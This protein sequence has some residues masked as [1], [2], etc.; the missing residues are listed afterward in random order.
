MKFTK[1]CLFVVLSMFACGS[2]A[3]TCADQIGNISDLTDVAKQKMISECEAQKLADI[4]AAAA[5]KAE[6]MAASADKWADVA[7]KFIGAISL[8]AQQLNQSV[9]EFLP[10]PAGILTASLIV[11]HVMG[12]DIMGIL[13][14]TGGMIFGWIIIMLTRAYCNK[15]LISKYE[16]K[17][18]KGWFGREKIID[19]PVYIAPTALTI[20][21]AS[22]S[23]TS[24]RDWYHGAMM[25]GTILGLAIIGISII[26][27]AV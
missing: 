2:Y 9:N 17:T 10:T 3:Y 19:V 8:V 27:L 12:D 16:Q 4:S 20:E 22:W 25:L 7:I 11:W 26:V 18:V 15:L 21:T 23:D 24:D 1:V 5:P 14:C 6:D 13:G